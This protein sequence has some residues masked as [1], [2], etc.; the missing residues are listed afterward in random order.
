MARRLFVGTRFPIKKKA[1]SKAFFIFI[2]AAEILRQ[3]EEDTA[4][5]N[6]SNTRGLPLGIKKE[7]KRFTLCRNYCSGVVGKRLRPLLNCQKRQCEIR[8]FKPRTKKW[9][10]F[11]QSATNEAPMY[12]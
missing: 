7:Q 4:E 9:P 5:K 1:F 6:T 12:R 10:S 11:S 8:Y 2:G 3:E